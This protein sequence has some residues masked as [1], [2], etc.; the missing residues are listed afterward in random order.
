[1]GVKEMTAGSIDSVFS[2]ISNDFNN[3]TAAHAF[4]TMGLTLI[5]D[6]LAKIP[7]FPENPDPIIQICAGHP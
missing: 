3:L 7:K 1:M 6:H 2:A 5:P 4:C